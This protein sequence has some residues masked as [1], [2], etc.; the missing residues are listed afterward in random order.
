VRGVEE[1]GGVDI[2]SFSP[3]GYRLVCFFFTSA[4][5]VCLWKGEEVGRAESSEAGR[6]R[7]RKVFMEER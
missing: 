1:L 4:V 5:S 3:M 7:R 6:K 2:V